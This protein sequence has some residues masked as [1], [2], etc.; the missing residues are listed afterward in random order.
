M[1]LPGHNG[2]FLDYH[3]TNVSYDEVLFIQINI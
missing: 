2:M 1:H 3:Q